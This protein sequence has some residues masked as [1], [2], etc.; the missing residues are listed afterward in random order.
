MSRADTFQLDCGCIYYQRVFPTGELDNQV[1]IYRDEDEGPCEV[2]LLQ[3]D[4][5]TDRVI[6]DNVIYN[7]IFKIEPSN[8]ESYDVYP[9]FGPFSSTGPPVLFNPP[10][11]KG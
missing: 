7:S 4:D 1:S 9:C 2:C 5:W 11:D 8:S 3:E 10:S 6:D